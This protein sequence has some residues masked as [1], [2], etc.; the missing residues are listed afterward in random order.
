MGKKQKKARIG[1]GQLDGNRISIEDVPIAYENEGFYGGA[2]MRA[3]RIRVVSEHPL[4][5]ESFKEK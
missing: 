1:Q 3:G 4:P 2:D 5:V